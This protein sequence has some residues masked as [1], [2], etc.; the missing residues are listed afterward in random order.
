MTSRAKLLGLS[1]VTAS[2]LL[3]SACG[4][5]AGE[6]ATDANTGKPQQGGTLTV[7]LGTGFAGSWPTG[8]DPATNTTGGAN[9][10]QMNAIYGGLFHLSGGGKGVGNAEVIPGLATGYEFSDGG[11]TLTIS[12][13]KG[14][15]FQDGTPFNAEAVAWNFRRS[16]ES[17]CTCNPQWP[18]RSEDAFTTPDS[19]TVVVHFSRPF[20]AAINGMPA[21][22]MNWMASPTAF[23]KMGEEKFKIKP[24]GAGPFEV[25]SNK[26]SS[27]LVL[28]ANPDF[29]KKGRPYLD[30]LIVKSIGGNQAAYQALLAGQAQ[31]YEG[32]ESPALVKQVKANDKLIATRQPPTSP[33]VIQL[34]TTGE[35][36]DEKRAREA[37]YYATNTK[38]I[39]EGLFN[40]KYPASQMFTGPGGLFHHAKVPGYRTYNPQKARAIVKELGGLKIELGTIKSPVAERVNTALQSQWEKVGI[41]TTIHSYQLSTLIQ[42]FDSNQWDAMLQTAGAWDPAA[43]IGIAPRFDSSSPY[44]G[45]KD[46]KLDQLIAEAEATL[47]KEKRDQLYQ[48]LGKY[49]SDNAYG[50]FLFAFAPSTV[51]VKGVHGPGITTK[52]PPVVV[53][54]GIIW[55]EVWMSESAR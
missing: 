44:T 53:N 40:G 34:N 43:G 16:S 1:L 41:D 39:S 35:P 32:M 26:L 49:I 10:T 45:V 36:F 6:T 12:L 30:K 20:A 18:L 25:V 15:K 21:N 29:W 28:K 8:L 46:K 3:A 48:Q 50:P 19:H 22:N 31:V 47:D 13:R 55:S 38:A 2:A 54:T 33:Y 37:I 24:V 51:A 23:E 11:K 14:V 52:I 27:E 4:G 17:P 7:L 42:K 9:L 5:S